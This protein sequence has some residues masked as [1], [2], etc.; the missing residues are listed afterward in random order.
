MNT[1]PLFERIACLS[2]EAVEVLYALG[3]EDCIAGISGYTT[4]PARARDEKPK[5]SGFSSAQIERILAVKPDLV[6]AYSN[7]QSEI[8]RELISAGIEVHAF[9][10]HHVAGILHMIKVL[11][12]LVGKQ[13]QGA[14]L[15]AE[16]QAQIDV[17]RHQAAQWTHRPKVYF[18]EWNEPLM[19]GIG[20][21]SELIQIAGG[22]DVFADLAGF[23]S[24]RQRIIADPAEVIRRAPDIIIGSWCGKKFRPDSVIAR[25][26]WDAI[27]AVRHGR[28]LE[29]KSADILSPGPSA[30]LHGLLQ[31][32]VLIAEWQASQPLSVTRSSV[33][34]EVAA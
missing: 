10:Q 33:A 14:Q 32:H 8:V 34:P 9:N 4:R 30:I 6:I 16:L 27:P 15:I 22:D 28:V 11:A 18:E 7:M 23:H 1:T 3:A 12:A 2:T 29:I 13:E 24:A 19:S 26:G 21:V 20:W 31:L 25:E 17:I 5:V